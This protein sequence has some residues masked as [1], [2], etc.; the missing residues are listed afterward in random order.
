MQVIAVLCLKTHRLLPSSV[1]GI[2]SI[3]FLDKMVLSNL[4]QSLSPCLTPRGHVLCV[5]GWELSLFTWEFIKLGFQLL[6]SMTWKPLW[7]RRLDLQLFRMGKRVHGRTAKLR[8]ILRP[9]PVTA[10]TYFVLYTCMCMC[11]T[12]CWI[13]PR[14][15]PGL[16]KFCVAFCFGSSLYFNYCHNTWMCV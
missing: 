6:V 16:K 1:V 13:E 10:R 2:M 11:G 8:T 4:S 14:K 15:I 12:F 3:I 7:S 9:L 5:V